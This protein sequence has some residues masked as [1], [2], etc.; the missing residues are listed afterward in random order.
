M[1]VG[2]ALYA[3]GRRHNVSTRQCKTCRTVVELAI[4]PEQSVVASGTECGGEICRDVVWYRTAKRLRTVPIRRMA[5]GVVAIRHGQAVIVVHVALVAVCGRACGCH[6]V[7]ACQCPT[8]GA[9]IEGVVGPGDGV[10][11][12]GAVCRGESATGGLV[13]RIIG[14]LPGGQV[15]ARVAAIRR[16]NA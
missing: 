6:L 4:R 10:M 5:A 11:T 7:V 1:A 16:L 8:C 14:L 2:A 13:R 9:V 3:A 15:A 12:S